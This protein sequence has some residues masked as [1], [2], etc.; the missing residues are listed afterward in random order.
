MPEGKKDSD[1]PCY[2]P[3]FTPDENA[4]DLNDLNDPLVRR[5]HFL[6]NSPNDS[7]WFLLDAKLGEGRAKIQEA[8]KFLAIDESRGYMGVCQS[9]HH[10][11]WMNALEY[12]NPLTHEFRESEESLRIRN[13]TY[14]QICGLELEH[15]RPTK[16]D[17]VEVIPLHS[18]YEQPESDTVF[19][20]G[21]TLPNN[22]V[23]FP[24]PTSHSS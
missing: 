10:R 22:V 24:G 8:L 15:S 2:S 1:L 21:E 9:W 11:D 5:L 3:R 13:M 6:E 20:D 16:G 18:N 23:N 4:L 19:T 12:Y 7:Y 14:S 17:T